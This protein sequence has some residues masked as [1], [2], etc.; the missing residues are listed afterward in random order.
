MLPKKAITPMEAH[1]LLREGKALL[2]DVREIQE[3]QEER[4]GG[5][6]LLPLSQFSLA[7]Y[8]AMDLNDK[9]LI[10]H[11]RSGVRSGQVCGMLEEADIPQL[12]CNLLGGILAWKAAGLPV[13]FGMQDP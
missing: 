2:V 8:Q 6:L 12:G 10:I 13:E 3:F 1:E 5:S 11:C 9:Q 7:D 4:I